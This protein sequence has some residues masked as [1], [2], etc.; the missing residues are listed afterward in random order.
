MIKPAC[1]TVRR[2]RCSRAIEPLCDVSTGAEYRVMSGVS[3]A[4]PLHAKELVRRIPVALFLV[5]QRCLMS[6]TE[7]LSEV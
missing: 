7:L 2:A 5:Y 4:G 3:G 1:R 6:G